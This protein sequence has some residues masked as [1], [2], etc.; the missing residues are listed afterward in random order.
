MTPKYM[1]LNELEWPF[2]VKFCFRAVGL[3]V[4]AWISKTAV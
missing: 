4:F 3:E 2:Y 1:T